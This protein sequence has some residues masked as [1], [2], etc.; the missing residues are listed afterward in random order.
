MAKRTKKGIDNTYLCAVKFW[1]GTYDA[2]PEWSRGKRL[3]TVVEGV[4]GTVREQGF[5]AETVRKAERRLAK[6]G[7]ITLKKNRGRITGVALTAKGAKVGCST[8]KLAPFTD[9]TY[10]GSK[11]SGL[12]GRAGKCK[13][14]TVRGKRRKLCWGR[15]GKL[16]SNTRAR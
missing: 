5:S 12:G 8:T 13:I 4:R 1:S 15:N 16:T 7:K 6:Q 11:L 2:A 9:H 10:R 14:I 3:N